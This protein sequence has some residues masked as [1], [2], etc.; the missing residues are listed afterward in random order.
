MKPDGHAHQGARA[1]QTKMSEANAF[2]I[3]HAGL[4]KST[5]GTLCDRGGSGSRNGPI[6]C[7]CAG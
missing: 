2:K 6:I 3:G 1:G 7:M 4:L 5:S